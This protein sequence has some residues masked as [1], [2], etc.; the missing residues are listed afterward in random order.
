VNFYYATEQPGVFE[1]SHIYSNT[2][3]TKYYA[4]EILRCLGLDVSVEISDRPDE[5]I[6]YGGESLYHYVG[7]RA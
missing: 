5:S 7:G 3:V 4:R 6:Q 1:G 2:Q